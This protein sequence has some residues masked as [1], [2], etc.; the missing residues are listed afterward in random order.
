MAIN[1][2]VTLIG[3]IGGEAEV[4]ETENSTFATL[5]FATTDSYKD[6]DSGE[7]IDLDT[8]WHKVITFNPKL[9]STLKSVK[10]GTRL[11]ITGSLSYRPQKVSTPDENGVLKEFNLP[12]ASVIA[13]KIELA[14]LAKRAK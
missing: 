9:I 7:W 4:I 2:T 14:P 3:N 11:E 5:S 10:K 13:R 1:N 12:V 8:V 6:E